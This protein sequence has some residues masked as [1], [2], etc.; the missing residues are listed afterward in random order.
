M[1]KHPAINYF[2]LVLNFISTQ[3]YF[4]DRNVDTPGHEEYVVNCFD[5]VQK[6]SLVTCLRMR[7]TP[8]VDNIDSKRMHVDSMTKTGEVSFAKECKRLMDICDEL[9]TK[10]DKKHAKREA[11]ALLNHKYY[12]LYKEEYILLNYMEDIYKVLNNQDEVTMRQFYHI[13]CYTDLDEGF[14]DM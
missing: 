3:S 12:C 2:S 8:G 1:L 13:L 5:A 6:R 7:S 10:G 4:L 11:K 9:G 14:C